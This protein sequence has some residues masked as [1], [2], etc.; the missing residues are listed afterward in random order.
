MHKWGAQVKPEMLMVWMTS[1]PNTVTL[2]VI[3]QGK[4]R[5]WKKVPQTLP[6]T[7]LW[8][9]V[10]IFLRL[11]ALSKPIWPHSIPNIR[12]CSIVLS[13]TLSH[14]KTWGQVWLWVR[15]S[16]IVCIVSHF[17]FICILDK[18]RDAFR[19]LPISDVLSREHPADDLL[20]WEHLEYLSI[21][22]H[23]WTTIPLRVTLDGL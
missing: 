15:F 8:S 13:R 12:L 23:P 6:K 5:A 21:P 18:I 9:V 14:T 20:E 19:R 22:V 17:P 10:K 11:W 4:R 3:Y 16:W 1:H 2:W 7:D